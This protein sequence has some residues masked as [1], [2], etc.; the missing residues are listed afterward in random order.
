MHQLFK[1]FISQHPHYDITGYRGFSNSIQINE[2]KQWGGLGPS[3]K[4]RPPKWLLQE[5]QK[6]YFLVNTARLVMLGQV[7]NNSDNSNNTNNLLEIKSQVNVQLA[8]TDCKKSL[9][10]SEFVARFAQFLT[11]FIIT[12]DGVLDHLIRL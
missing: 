5:C 8:L 12:V 11:T 6:Y 3:T 7:S 10:C 2:G 1:T 4:T 9:W